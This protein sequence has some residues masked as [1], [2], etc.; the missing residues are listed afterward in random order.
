MKS[1]TTATAAAPPLEFT[2]M[3]GAGND[4]IMID[5]RSGLVTDPVELCKRI[6][7]RRL[8]AGADGMILIESSSQ[9]TIRMRYYNADGSVGDFC[10]NGARCAARFAFLGGMAPETMSIETGAGNIG[11]EVRG[12]SVTLSLPSPH[13]FRP[14]RPLNLGD[15]RV[16]G[17][18]IVV[19]VPHYVSFLA[20]SLWDQ[21]IVAPGRRIRHHEDLR[22][23]GANANFVVVK[24]RHALEVRTYERGV[25]DETLA[26]GSGVVASVAVSAL[27]GRVDSPVAVLTRSGITL[28]V[29]FALRGD[30]VDQIRLTGDARLVYRASMTPDTV[31][32]FD[33]R[34]VTR[35]TKGRVAP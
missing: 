1:V 34:W 10:G 31:D 19:G 8:S 12:N 33:P 13:S 6:C 21:D 26:C 5:N 14:S 4:F 15:R 30:Q 17:S 25:E 18:S 20:G 11:A 23:D 2:K 35:P 3:A 7:T 9:A 16:D 28:E 27:F 22:P 24:E 32:G 29:S